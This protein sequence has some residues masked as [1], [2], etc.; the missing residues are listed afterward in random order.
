MC[1]RVYQD[2]G[3]FS[4]KTDIKE[5]ISI[6]RIFTIF[7]LVQVQTVQDGSKLHCAC[8]PFSFGFRSRFYH[9]P[10][11]WRV[12]SPRLRTSHSFWVAVV[13]VVVSSSTS[14]SSTSFSVMLL[15]CSVD[16]YVSTGLLLMRDADD[17]EFR[18]TCDA[19]TEVEIFFDGIIRT[20]NELKQAGADPFRAAG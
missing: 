6:T 15:A 19:E 20:A 3:A 17:E 16:L 2:A 8:F 14:R 11:Q 9:K 7:C 13:G 18:T 5:T 4:S 1:E 10:I 12:H